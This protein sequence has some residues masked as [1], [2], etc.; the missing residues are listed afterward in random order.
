MNCPI[1]NSKQYFTFAEDTTCEDIWKECLQCGHKENIF[2]KQGNYNSD[3]RKFMKIGGDRSTYGVKVR[4]TT[5]P[6]P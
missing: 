2:V 1:C 6:L 5:L 3:G 4:C